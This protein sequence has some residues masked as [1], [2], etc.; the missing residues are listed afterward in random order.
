MF[1]SI[2]S[3]TLLLLL[4]HYSSASYFNVTADNTFAFWFNGVQKIALCPDANTVETGSSISNCEWTDTTSFELGTSLTGGSLL[5]LQGHDALGANTDPLVG[6]TNP[7]AVIYTLTITGVGICDPLLYWTC[8]DDLESRTI[9]GTASPPSAWATEVNFDTSK[10]T[11]GPLD[12]LGIN[13]PQAWADFPAPAPSLYNGDSI[14][15]HDQGTST[16]V[17]VDGHWQW[18]RH[19]QANTDIFCRIVIPT[20]G[21]CP[22]STENPPPVVHPC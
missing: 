11:T 10:W 12:D 15:F 7:G 8:I 1:K 2:L 21:G 13:G 19:T 22:A 17:A 14:W 20:N 3:V 9:Y 4:I 5:A 16:G 6:G 18:F